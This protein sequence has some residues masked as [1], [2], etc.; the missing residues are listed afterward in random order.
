VLV[1]ADA[2]GAEEEFVL[3]A[4]ELCGEGAGGALEIGGLVEQAAAL[5]DG[6]EALE[7][8]GSGDAGV[9]R[10]FGEIGIHGPLAGLVPDEGD[11]QAGER[12]GEVG[13]GL[14][15][16]PLGVAVVAVEDA[17]AAAR[18]EYLGR[19]GGRAALGGDHEVVGGLEGG[20]PEDVVGTVGVEVARVGGAEADD[21]G[22]HEG[23]V[24]A[25]LVAEG[26][27]DEG[28]MVAV[29]AE[30]CL[31]LGMRKSRTLASKVPQKGSSGWRYI[32]RRSAAAK[33]ARAESR[34]GSGCG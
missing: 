27:H 6:A 18:G 17:E 31:G 1:A 24:A 13:A 8:V 15:R 9:L 34:C 30:Q 14:G 25:H 11:G 21:H 3:L 12:G 5:G 32:P 19:V 28:G 4:V 2:G 16:A 7:V 23:A 22:V 29:F 33:A 20:V 10:D 26:E